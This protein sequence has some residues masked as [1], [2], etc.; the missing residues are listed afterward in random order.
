[1]KIVFASHT[2]MNS[3]YKVGSFHLAKGLSNK[4]HEVLHISDAVSVL[5]LMK[6]KDEVV[7]SKINQI[8]NGPVKMNDST[9][10]FI[11]FSLVPNVG[12]ISTISNK[13]KRNV[14][15]STS[16]NF[17]KF[18]KSFNFEE[19]D[20]IIVDSVKFA[21]IEKYIKTKVLIYRPTDIYSY[22]TN[23]NSNMEKDIIYRADE[24]IATSTPLLAYLKEKYEILKEIHV[25][26]NG[27]DYNHFNYH[28]SNQPDEYAQINSPRIIYVG[29]MD[30][31]FD[32]SLIKRIAQERPGYNVV[33]V[34]P[35]N[36]T[37]RDYFKEC[38]NVFLLGSKN[39]SDLPQFMHNSDA[40][41]LP[42]DLNNE[43]NHGRS[44]MKLYEYI[45]SGLQV[46]SMNTEELQ[47]RNDK[48]VLLANDHSEFIDQLDYIVNDKYTNKKDVSSYGQQFSWKVKIER[49]E[50][51]LFRR[52]NH[53]RMHRDV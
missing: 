46:V 1:M 51:I 7:K 28:K 49:I 47:K 4:G 37:I 14:A 40:A 32:F 11:P 16:F 36:Q 12:I 44:P 34:G 10:D 41:I 53:K 27:V 23:I 30:E 9:Y 45:A 2:H 50:D 17:R 18:L 22:M 5:H 26:E 24:L 29:S 13:L 19:V 35:Y 25:I 52:L 42:L 43:A 8:K 31:R 3:V 6:R 20:A 48:Y 21:F 39:F 38:K 33:L 15:L